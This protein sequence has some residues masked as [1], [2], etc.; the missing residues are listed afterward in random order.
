MK[1][2]FILATLI[3]LLAL[4]VFVTYRQTSVGAC[5]WYGY[6][7]QSMLLRS[8]QLTMETDIDA[9]KYPCVAPL[10]YYERKGKIV[11]HYPSGYPILLAI[12]GAVGLAFFVNPLLGSL[13]FILMYLVILEVFKLNGNPKSGKNAEHWVALMFSTIWVFSPIV[14][15]GSVHVMSDLPAAFFVLFAYYLFL[16]DKIPAAALTLG[17]SILIRPNNI[18]FALVLLPL[19]YK[20]RKLLSLGIWLSFSL[21]ISAFYNWYMHG[22]P[23]RYGFYETKLL[24]TDTKLL[25]HLIYYSREIFLQITPVLLILAAIAIWRNRTKALALCGWFLAYLVFYSFLTLGGVFWWEMRFML[26]ALPP[27]FILAACGFLELSNSLPQKRHKWITWVVGVIVTLC[28]VGYFIHF[29][30]KS[31]LFT[32]DK[33]EQFRVYAEHVKKL[34]PPNSI[35]GAFELSGPLRLYGNLESINLTHPS[36]LE[37]IRKTLQN[38]ER[39]V[40]VVYEPIAKDMPFFVTGLQSFKHKNV[41]VQEGLYKYYLIRL[42][43]NKHPE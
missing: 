28:L 17:F 39:P 40:F 9:S 25:S 15:W 14:I 34:V 22:S 35:V 32:R 3:P 21:G 4:G 26:S 30:E 31:R 13:S 18:L 33:A 24:L 11:P 23:L 38:R 7:S 12:F 19:A 41:Q 5:D 43:S 2:I 27:I 10:S 29:G 37:L 20:R 1:S 42:I 36:S 8:G 16:K 6:Y